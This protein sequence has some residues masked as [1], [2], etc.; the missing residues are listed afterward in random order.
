MPGTTPPALGQVSVGLEIN[1][2]E[3]E[4]QRLRGQLNERRARIDRF[5]NENSNAARA[6]PYNNQPS[7][8]SSSPRSTSGKS[9]SAQNL[10]EPKKPKRDPSPQEH[11][12][13]APLLQPLFHAARPSGD[14]ASIAGCC[15]HSEHGLSGQHGRHGGRPRSDRSGIFI[16]DAR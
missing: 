7:S 15:A 6:C 16:F 4:L 8:S 11:R 2:I 5:T 10:T 14:A 12:I 1:R 13:G 3:T 9:R